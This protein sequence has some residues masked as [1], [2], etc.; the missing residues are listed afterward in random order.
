MW[1]PDAAL[2]YLYAVFILALISPIFIIL[3]KNNKT[4]WFFILI[5]IILINRLNFVSATWAV[6]FRDYGYIG[7]VLAY[8][9]SYLVGAYYGMHIKGASCA[10]Q[11]K[12]VV[13]ILF[14]ALIFDG[15]YSGFLCGI[16]IKMLPILILY[17]FPVTGYMK[18]KRIFKITFLM[19]AMHQPVIAD[20]LVFVRDVISRIT[21]YAFISNILTRI[22]FLAL[23]IVVAGIIYLGLKKFAP[24][25]LEILTGGRS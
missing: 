14:T 7:N 12:Y 15:L 25:V 13:T 18:S 8:F 19:Y 21:P 9:P 22:T 23:N 1:P 2:W 17:S 3:F 24:K 11:F 5:I 16:T 10:E 20:G 4:G 6:T